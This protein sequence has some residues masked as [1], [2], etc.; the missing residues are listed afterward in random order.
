MTMNHF[1]DAVVAAVFWSSDL[2]LS[3]LK[4]HDAP[5]YVQG[6]LGIIKTYALHRKRPSRLFP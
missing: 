6:W 1:T 2:P 5:S 4:R 3:S